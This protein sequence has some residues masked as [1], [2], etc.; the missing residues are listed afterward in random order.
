MSQM[1]YQIM[2][3]LREE[4]ELMPKPKNDCDCSYCKA[5]AITVTCAKCALFDTCPY[6]HGCHDCVEVEY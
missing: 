4:E 2:S 1:C 6:Y 5:K 3:M